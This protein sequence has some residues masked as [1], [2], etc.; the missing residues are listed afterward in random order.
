[1][2]AGPASSFRPARVDAGCVAEIA[3]VAAAAAVTV[4][5]V[6]R[7]AV[8]VDASI[9]TIGAT[10]AA[11]GAITPGTAAAM[12]VEAEEEDADVK[13]PA[14]AVLGRD[15]ASCALVRAATAAERPGAEAVIVTLVTAAPVPRR[16]RSVRGPRPVTTVPLAGATPS[17]RGV[18]SR[19]RAHAAAPE[20]R[21]PRPGPDPD[22]TAATEIRTTIRV[23]RRKYA[24]Y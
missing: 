4:A 5:E 19:R 15:R 7:R 2:A 18:L 21:G 13:D 10:S 3:A 1:M 17:H 12:G 9:R 24:N 16:Q 20:R 8:R 11:D 6:G 14:A 23:P 22:R